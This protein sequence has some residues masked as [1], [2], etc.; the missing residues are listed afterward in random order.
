MA[1]EE[2]G[3]PACW[4]HVF[5]DDEVGVKFK[6]ELELNGKTA[7]GFGVPQNV[8]EH[9]GGGKRPAVVVSFNGYS[10]RTT[11][12]SM[13]GRSMI[14]VSAEHRAA[15]GVVAG[16]IVQLDVVLDDKAR[17]VEVPKYVADAFEKAGVRE[18]FD[19][20]SF[21][22]RKEHVRAIEDA[23]SEETRQRRIDKAIEKLRG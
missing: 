9:L 14:P 20:L 5:D 23:K 12:G 11:I 16:D 8:V 1:H 13:G 4:A 17:D 6:A 2:G 19:K 15:S 10:Y 22:H 21:S 7:T 18:A 3:D